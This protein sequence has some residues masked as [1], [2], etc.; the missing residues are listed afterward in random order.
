MGGAEDLILDGKSLFGRDTE[1]TSSKRILFCS[2][3]V[4]VLM[5]PVLP[6]RRALI[7]PPVTFRWADFSSAH[8]DSPFYPGS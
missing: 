6:T 5:S 4:P 1:H 8:L 2:V 3:N 7:K